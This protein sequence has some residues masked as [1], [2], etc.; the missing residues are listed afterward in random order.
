MGRE[1]DNTDIKL[2]KQIALRLKELREFSGKNQTQFA[3]NYGKDKQTQNRL[4]KGRGATIYSI[5]KF[6]KA[7]GITLSEFFNSPL[8]K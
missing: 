7:I 6:C 3:Y 2:R 1:L 4:E 5:N 8:F